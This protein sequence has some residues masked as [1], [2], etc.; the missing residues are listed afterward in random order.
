[1]T[2]KKQLLANQRNA[3]KSTGPLSL[4]GKK[5]ASQNSLRHGLLSKHLTIFDEIPKDL[6]LFREHI[7][8]SLSPEG[9]IEELLTEKIINASWRLARLARIEVAILNKED[10]FDNSHLLSDLF[11]GSKGNSLEL[12]SRYESSLERSF[13]KALHELQHLQAARTGHPVLTPISIDITNTDL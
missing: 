10:L 2:S 9:I 7:Y 5:R 3:Q 8:S 13:Y 6:T 1:M 12:L 4:S 11:L